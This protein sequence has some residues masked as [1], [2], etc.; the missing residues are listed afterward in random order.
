[1]HERSRRAF[2]TQLGTAIDVT[3]EGG[4]APW[5]YA[6]WASTPAGTWMADNAWRYGFVMSYPPTFVR[7]HLLRLRA[8][9]LPLRRARHGRT[10]RCQRQGTA[11]VHLGAPVDAYPCADAGHAPP[12]RPRRLWLDRTAYGPPLRPRGPWPDGLPG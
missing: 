10:D 11:P 4:Q 7:S 3:S 1:A 5:E 12:P 6:D 2:R 9:A 8:M